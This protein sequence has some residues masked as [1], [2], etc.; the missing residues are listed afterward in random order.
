MN[1][2]WEVVPVSVVFVPS[3]LLDVSVLLG[4]VCSTD[5]HC[6][7]TFSFFYIPF[8]APSDLLITWSPLVLHSDN[9]VINNYL[10]GMI[11]FYN[12]CPHWPTPYTTLRD[13]IETL[14]RQDFLFQTIFLGFEPLYRYFSPYG[15]MKN[16]SMS[17]NV[18]SK[19]RFYL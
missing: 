16:R 4:F 3:R 19:Y 2:L 13:M 5:L 6:R 7:R 8:W 17:G 18:L 9:Q 11:I 14:Q 1:R 15:V 12:Y 10:Y